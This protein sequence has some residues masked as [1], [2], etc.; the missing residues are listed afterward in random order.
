MTSVFGADRACSRAARFGVSPTTPPLLRCALANQIANHG[1]PGGDAEP[2]AE[3][4]PRRQ[5]TDRLDH[6]QPGAHRPLRIVLMRLWVGVL[7]AQAD[8]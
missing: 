4:F 1:E 5:L 3:I 6:R 8:G 7:P 2:H